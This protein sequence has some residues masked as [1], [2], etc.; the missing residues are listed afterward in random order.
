[1]TSCIRDY[2]QRGEEAIK[3]NASVR[4]KHTSSLTQIGKEA[5]L[6]LQCT[7]LATENLRA[8]FVPCARTR[9]SISHG[10]TVTQRD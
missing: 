1:M 10:A 2:N 4:R 7:V 8:G 9:P 3:S 6:S 5:Q